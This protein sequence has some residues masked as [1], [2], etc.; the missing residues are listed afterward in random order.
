MSLSTF[1]THWSPW[2]TVGGGHGIW[3]AAMLHAILGALCVQRDTGPACD[4]AAACRAL[5]LMH[6]ADMVR[7]AV[8]YRVDGGM[9]WTP[10]PSA[11]W[12]TDMVHLE[13]HL[14]S[15]SVDAHLVVRP[16]PHLVTSPCCVAVLDPKHRR[17]LGWRWKRVPWAAIARATTNTVWSPITVAMSCSEMMDVRGI[18]LVLMS[19]TRDTGSW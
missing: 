1:G 9:G 15:V 8:P 4:A 12:F 11:A 2:G 19:S 5:M 10:L 18:H 7:D 6:H 14:Q 16:A 17:N 13:F 3:V